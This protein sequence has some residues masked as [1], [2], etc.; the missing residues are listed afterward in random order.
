MV[1][2]FKH[3]LLQLDGMSQAKMIP[4]LQILLTLNRMNPIVLAHCSFFLKALQGDVWDAVPGRSHPQAKVESA[5][6]NCTNLSAAHT[7]QR[8][9]C[10]S[11][12]APG[13]D[14]AEIK[15]LT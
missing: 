7:A 12:Q 15:P 10:N 14:S 8:R 3:A 5:S 1:W 4:I 9:E 2:P 6:A 13:L 11:Q